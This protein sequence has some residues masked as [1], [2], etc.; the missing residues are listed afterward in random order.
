MKNIRDELEQEK[1]D[2]LNYIVPLD[3]EVRRDVYYS[4]LHYI[5]ILKNK[6]CCSFDNMIMFD[7]EVKKHFT[8]NFYKAM[9][10]VSGVGISIESH[11]FL[12][13]NII[14]SIGGYKFKITRWDLGKEEEAQDEVCKID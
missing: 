7:Y 9:S 10:G 12:E 8:Q 1:K 4:Y 3:K 5:S 13:L 14:Y 2:F 6:D 11:V